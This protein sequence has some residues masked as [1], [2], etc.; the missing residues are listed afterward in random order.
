M[1]RQ[2]RTLGFGKLFRIDRL[3][4]Q[5]YEISQHVAR[6]L[7][8]KGLAARI[9]QCFAVC[10]SLDKTSCVSE[11]AAASAFARSAVT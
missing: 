3:L 5:R 6:V 1:N 7:V 10:S 2:Y 11:S 4:N 9:R 8:Q